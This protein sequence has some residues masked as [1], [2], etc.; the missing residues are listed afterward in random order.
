MLKKVILLLAVTMLFAA[1]CQSE[2]PPPAPQPPAQPPP[3]PP[4]QPITPPQPLEDFTNAMFG[5]RHKSDVILDGATTYTV[6]SGDTLVKIARQFYQDGAYYPLILLVSGDVVADPD[7]IEPGMQLTIP[8]L[9]QNLDD[10]KAKQ[11][12]FSYLLDMAKLEEQR[13]RYATALLLRDHAK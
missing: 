12:I 6:K 8:V 3:P 2:P 9:K 13:G 10:S 1:A 11:S 5:N 4:P 7:R